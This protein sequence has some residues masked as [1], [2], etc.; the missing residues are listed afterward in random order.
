MGDGTIDLKNDDVGD[1]AFKVR[2]YVDATQNTAFSTTP[3]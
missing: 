1:I 2:R 3:S